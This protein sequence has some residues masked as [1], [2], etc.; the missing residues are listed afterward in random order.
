[1]PLHF[2][3]RPRQ[4]PGP[5]SAAAVN[6]APTWTDIERDVRLGL[7]LADGRATGEVADVL[8][9][10]LRGYLTLLVDDAEAYAAALAE[11]RSKDVA[12]STIRRARVLV[13]QRSPETDPATHLRLL[14]KA[15]DCTAR[16][17]A[18]ARQIRHRGP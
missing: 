8:R 1:M 13:Q 7:A 17:A 14:S 6:G 15:V 12:S 9:A 4:M 2:P 3:H 18:A 16:Y 11:G 10:R 5:P